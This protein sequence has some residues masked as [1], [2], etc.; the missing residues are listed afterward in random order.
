MHAKAII[1]RDTMLTNLIPYELCV[2][3]PNLEI[4]ANL[5]LTFV[6]ALLV[7]VR[8]IHCI[9]WAKLRP[10]P[11]LTLANVVTREEVGSNEIITAPA[12]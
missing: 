4:F 1:I 12:T 10:G 3:I 9:F 8:D 5:R 6:Q 2:S 11:R 7:S